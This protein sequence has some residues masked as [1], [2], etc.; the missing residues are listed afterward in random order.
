MSSESASSPMATL[1]PP[2]PKSFDFLI[3]RVTSGR[4][5][6][7]SSLRSSGALPFCTSLPHVSSELGIV[8][9]RRARGAADAVAARAAAQHDDPVARHGA[10]APHVR[11]LHGTDHG[12]DLQPLG[13]VVV[14]VDLAHVRRGQTDLV[15]V[16]RVARR[17]L[18]R[19]DALRQLARERVAHLLVDVA[20]T[21]HAHRLVDV[22][23]ARQRIADRAAQAG[24]GAA[25]GL[26]LRRVVVRFVLELHEPP[27]RPAVDI[28]VDV[29]RAGVV[30]VRDLQVVEQPL[31]A[32][33]AR[34]DRRHVHQ[35]DALVLAP[36]LAPHAQVEGQRALDLLLE[37]RLL[38]GDALQ[39]GREGRMAA[40][41]AP[42]GIQDPQL[43]LVRGRAPRRGSNVTTSRRS[44]A[45]IA[46][47][48]SLQK[49][50]SAASSI[51]RNP[52]STCTGFTSAC[53]MSESTAR[54][55]SRD[56]TALM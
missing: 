26:D 46:S 31:P 11:G 5:N 38:D 34:A 7:R 21:R 41:V 3:R 2:A 4:R 30:L 20:R 54:S 1:T 44:S 53:S 45:F 28:H 6:S 8:L 22:A 32:Q 12:T 18:L 42:V 10:F 33:V 24:R 37:E 15:A 29:D 56:S 43:R 13:H 16:A 19:D 35:A 40:V 50:S 36:Q 14:V 47:P 51:S 25:E 9:L 17:G 27:L 48:Y 23:A 39:L 52:S 55:F 49:G